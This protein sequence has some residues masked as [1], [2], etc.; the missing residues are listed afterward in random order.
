MGTPFF[1]LSFFFFLELLISLLKKGIS[2]GS[3]Y[4]SADLTSIHEDVGSIPGL[5]QWVED[6]ASLASC[7]R[8]LMWLKSGVAVAVV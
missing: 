1:F 2:G 4:G 5:A 8:S 6:P 7:S 3:R